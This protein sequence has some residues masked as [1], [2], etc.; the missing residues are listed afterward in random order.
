MKRSLAKFNPETLADAGPTSGPPELAVVVP[1]LNERDNVGPLIER[2][3][4]A[5]E[6]IRWEAIFVDDDSRDGTADLLREIG[7]S[8]PTFAANGEETP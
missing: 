3:E 2:L 6:G 4:S 5:L 7:R 1:T 8:N